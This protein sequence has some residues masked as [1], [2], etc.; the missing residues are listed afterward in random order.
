MTAAV[1]GITGDALMH[2]GHATVAF[3]IWVAL[4]ALNAVALLWR[5]GRSASGETVAWLIGS[6]VFA[7]ALA[8]RNSEELQAF[9]V[10]AAIA[11]LGMAAVSIRDSGAALFA[12]RLRDTVFTA[13]DVVGGIV[14]GVLPLAFREALLN[15][16]GHRAASR[17]RT[18]IRPVVIAALALL[19][20]GSLLRSADPIF[21]SIWV[22][23]SFDFG[24]VASHI[25]LSGFF[26]W[27]IA[28][29][30]RAGL[31]TNPTRHRAAAALPIELDTADVFA[32]LGTLIVVFGAFIATQ[33]GWFFG[34]EQFLRA[35]T[36]LTAA[37]YARQGFFQMVVVVALVLPVLVGTRA[38]LR[39]GPALARL[40]TLL[41]LP[42]ILLLGAIIASA[43]LRMKMYTHYYGLTTDRFYPSVFMLWLA[44]VVVWLGLTVLR[45][46]GRPFVAGAVLSGLGTLL[47]LNVVDPDA[48]VARVNIARAS[49]PSANGQQ[50][51]DLLHLATLRGGGVALATRALIESP[52]PQVPPVDASGDAARRAA[53]QTHNDRC[54][55]AKLLLSRWGP[56]SSTRIRRDKDGAWRSWNWDDA[57]A[58]RAVSTNSSALREVEHASCAISPPTEPSGNSRT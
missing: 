47:I 6:V 8:W 18:F 56:L 25:L 13:A 12:R 30:A 36:G 15:E 39:P 21:A 41:S 23:P 52:A 11:C 3:G 19:I 32:A 50:S 55:A 27:V 51:L 10:L 22:L 28:G 1:I 40:H 35:R 34:G 5:A 37:S 42:V 26:T 45:D 20:F 53:L 43:M 2:D 38:A 29:W 48:I 57:I 17:V 7:A 58:M 49:S 54:R 16:P 9:D 44:V 4:I 14:I 46:W 33:L 31:T 24:T